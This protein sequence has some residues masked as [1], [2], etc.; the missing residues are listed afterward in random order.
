MQLLDEKQS[1]QTSGMEGSS[2]DELLSA[3]VGQVHT[4]CVGSLCESAASRLAYA[5][6][7]GH[8]TTSANDLLSSRVMIV[9]D[10]PINVKAA[11]KFVATLG[12]LNFVTL[13]DSRKVVAAIREE[14]PDVLLLDLMM[15]DVSGLDI[16]EAMQSDTK[17][18]RIPVIILTA[19]SDRGTRL[20]ALELGATDFLAKPLDL[21]E[22]A[23]RLRNAL[24]MRD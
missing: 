12:Y 21:E 14:A 20:R 2:L 16:L 24:L 19:S 22:L 5:D 8:L 13:T 1:V 3:V 7:S 11:K 17:L 6:S 10:E 9:D 15:P 23:P 4:D 18:K